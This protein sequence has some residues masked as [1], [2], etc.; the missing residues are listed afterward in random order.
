MI[1]ETGFDALFFIEIGASLFMVFELPNEKA[2]QVKKGKW[3]QMA[4]KPGSVQRL[5]SLIDSYSSSQPVTWLVMQPTRTSWQNGQ[6]YKSYS[7]HVPIWS[8]SGWGLPWPALLPSPRC[9]LTAPFH[10]YLHH[11]RRFVFCGTIPRVAPAGRYPASS[12]CGART[13]LSQRYADSSYP[14]IWPQ[15]QWCLI[16]T[17]KASWH[18]TVYRKSQMIRRYQHLMPHASSLIQASGFRSLPASAYLLLIG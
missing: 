9:A 6:C 15:C 13:F 12:S 4:Y 16:L 5:Y 8:C 17:K 18:A 1:G 7:E 14:A 2:D 3:G 10:P 11:G